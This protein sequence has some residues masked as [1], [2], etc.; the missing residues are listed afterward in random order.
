MPSQSAAQ[1]DRAAAGVSY[2][3]VVPRAPWRVAEVEALCGWRLRV[4]HNDG[5]TGTVD[6]TALVHSPGAGM[7]AAL[8]DEALFAQVYLDL[9]A[10]TWPG[11]IDLSPYAMH[12]AIKAHGEWVLR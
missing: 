7:F 3:P 1:E 4:R 11:E 2:P 9:G 8:K 5:V 12:E 6:M 10:V